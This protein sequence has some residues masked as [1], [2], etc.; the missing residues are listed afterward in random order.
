MTYLRVLQK[1]HDSCG[2]SCPFILVSARVE[3]A[4]EVVMSVIVR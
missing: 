1:S 2:L 4:D 3:D